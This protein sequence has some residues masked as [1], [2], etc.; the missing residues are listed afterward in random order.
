MASFN[1]FEL[2]ALSK[3]F[4]GVSARRVEQSILCDGATYIRR[5]ERPS[6]LNLT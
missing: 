2:A 6:G 5:N 3:L 4:Q 1:R